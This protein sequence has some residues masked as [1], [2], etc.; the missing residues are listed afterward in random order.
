M[1]YLA[2]A[3]VILLT[4]CSTTVPV[5]QKFP[6]APDTLR[7]PCPQLDTIKDPVL[8]SELTKSVTNNY[9][10]YHTCAN[11]VDAWN[12]WYA[13]QKKIFDDAQ[14]AKLSK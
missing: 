6:D 10:T 12:D 13:K 8:L 4:G 1:K 2:L 7:Q 11:R 5:Q 9:T 14:K 3:C